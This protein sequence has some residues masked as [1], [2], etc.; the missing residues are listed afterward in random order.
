MT[1]VMG[2]RPARGDDDAGAVAILVAVLTSAVLLTVGALTV[3][4][5]SAWAE[6]VGLR[7]VAESAA[8]AAAA[9]LPEDPR[10][11]SGDLSMD[12]RADV[13]AAAVQVLCADGNRRPQWDAP[14]ICPLDPQDADWPVNTGADGVDLSDGA[15]VVERAEQN[16]Y[17]D[18]AAGQLPWVVRVVTPP[19]RVDF[20]LARAGGVDHVDVQAAG[21]ARRGLQFPLE[22]LYADTPF[23]ASPYYLT[24]QDLEDAP[25]HSLVC[26]RTTP[27]PA[28]EPDAL[29]DPPA[30]APQTPPVF[31]FE[32][33]G[34]DSLDVL[35]PRTLKL[36]GVRL[37]AV[38][39]PAEGGEIVPVPPVT[40]YVG[41][42]TDRHAATTTKV[43]YDP[44][45]TTYEVEVT[46]PDLTGSPRYGAV[47]VWFEYDDPA[48]ATG[49]GDPPVSNAVG[50]TYP[51]DPDP[52][53]TT[54]RYDCDSGT[55]GR[56]LLAP[57]AGDGTVRDTVGSV[58]DGLAPRVHPFGS[59]PRA[60]Q[61][62]LT[63]EDCYDYA[64]LNDA[65]V[66]PGTTGAGDDDANCLPVRAG[67]DIAPE[68]LTTAWLG[69]QGPQPVTGRL[70]RDEGCSDER[71]TLPGRTGTFD[72][73]S[74]FT[75]SNGL[76]TSGVDTTALSARISAGQAPDAALRN[77]ITPK[78][79]LCP[80]LLLVP[81]L[82]VTRPV[83][84]TGH[85]A[86]VGMTY[87]WVTGP[88]DFRRPSTYR[89]LVTTDDSSVVVGI[90][91]W[92]IDPLYVQGGDWVAHTQSPDDA[93]P[94]AVPKRAVLVRTPC[95]GHP[96]SSECS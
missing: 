38:P 25:A 64:G 73:T 10:T 48:F 42:S 55:D 27:L 6:R 77:Q 69:T 49:T 91:G 76:V 33:L 61:A 68:D 86:V 78:V 89:G 4:L 57:A 51:Q 75:R 39:P 65:L 94:M 9:L 13:V 85:H 23:S 63:D 29:P 15:V 26:L 44:A 3:D 58:R 40:V 24:V 11:P 45:T 37:G 41:D 47:W 50:L 60:Q 18:L 19:V 36:T 88:R 67:N 28:V 14:S 66:R 16:A 71:R 54:S 30:Q 8:L 96:D 52:V 17:P 21:G 5:G 46:T 20:G 92:I 95:D 34:P 87:F 2:R 35:A 93:L 80:R 32:T 22:A 84:G 7:S 12:L 83:T 1:R 90:S 72:R 79:F 43:K 31:S 70:Q 62:P 56:G 53:R 82:D 81:V 59:W 74:L